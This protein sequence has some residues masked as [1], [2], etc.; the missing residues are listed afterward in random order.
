MVS[1]SYLAFS[2]NSSI[3]T[4]TI[5]EGVEYISVEA[6]FGCDA[7]ITI[8]LPKTCEIGGGAFVN[9]C[10]KVATINLPADHPSL[11][12]VDGV[13]YTKDNVLYSKYGRL[14]WYSPLKEDK[15]FYVPDG[16]KTIEDEVFADAYNLEEVHI[17]ESVTLIE[18]GVFWDCC[19]LKKIYMPYSIKQIGEYCLANVWGVTVYG[20]ENTPV[21]TFCET[22]TDG[23]VGCTFQ[24]MG[25]YEEVTIKKNETQTLVA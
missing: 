21:Q 7:L 25:R 5:S 24:S 1:I 15:I 11:K 4:I 20:Y 9:E 10:P 17:P 19:N 8:N 23:S 16:I 14:T 12:L 22:G 13:L 18:R 6:I 3:E 2:Y